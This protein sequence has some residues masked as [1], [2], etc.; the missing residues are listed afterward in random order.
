MKGL[1]ISLVVVA[2]SIFSIGSAEAQERIVT[3]KV[4]R[5][6]DVL[7]GLA[8]YGKEAT[9]KTAKGVETMLEGAGEVITAPFR[10][11]LKWPKPR[12]FHWHKGYWHEQKPATPKLKIYDGGTIEDMHYLPAPYKPEVTSTIVFYERKF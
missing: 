8:D 10:S 5:P 4:V 9:C 11:K 1:I 3:Y 2:T 7:R 12:I 6:V